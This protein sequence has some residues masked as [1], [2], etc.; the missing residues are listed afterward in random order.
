MIQELTPAA[1]P[2]PSST[3]AGSSSTSNAKL[4]SSK[5]IPKWLQKGL[6]NK[7]K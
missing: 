7:K 1:S 6:F 2:Q 4:S 3:T 5:P